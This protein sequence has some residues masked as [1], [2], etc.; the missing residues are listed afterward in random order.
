MT[1]EDNHQLMVFKHGICH[2]AA[3]RRVVIPDLLARALAVRDDSPVVSQA[4]DP[5]SA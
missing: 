2:E 1:M 5:G 3:H 4:V